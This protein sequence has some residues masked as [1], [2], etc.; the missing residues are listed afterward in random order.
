MDYKLKGYGL[1]CSQNITKGTFVIEYIG[2]RITKNEAKVQLEWKEASDCYLFVLVEHFGETEHSFYIDAR[3]E[4]NLARFINHS[5]QSNLEMIPVR[6]NY[7]DPHFALFASKDITAGSELTFSYGHT[8]PIYNDEQEL[9]KCLCQS[10][11]CSGFLPF[12][13]L[14]LI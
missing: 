7:H 1:T 4:G 5:C 14:R 12:T 8:N 3:D 6:I 10:D 11:N 9:K 13:A 2:K